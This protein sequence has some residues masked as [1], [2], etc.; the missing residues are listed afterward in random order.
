M[1]RN[2]ELAIVIFEVLFSRFNESELR[3]LCF[4]LGVDYDNLG[5]VGGQDKAR[6]LV[7]YFERRG[8]LVAI[9]DT[10]KSIRADISWGEVSTAKNDTDIY[11]RLVYNSC[12]EQSPLFSC[13]WEWYSTVDNHADHIKKTIRSSDGFPSLEFITYGNE[14]VGANKHI[15]SV[16][17]KVD[18]EYL[19]IS[20]QAQESNIIIYIIPAQLNWLD[21][22]PHQ[23]EQLS[24]KKFIIPKDHIGDNDWHKASIDFDF[25]DYTN[26]FLA[27][28]APR[29]NE[30]CLYTGPARFLLSNFQI[31]AP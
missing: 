10:I 25:R 3:T 30:G 19:A 27:I 16:L 20:S 15:P 18:F 14:D 12:D 8:N 22:A 13:F 21:P 1:T 11:K 28:F 23:I 26:A 7:Q 5:G 6:E 29:I 9:V 4:Y 31:Y 24:R 17:G 2:R